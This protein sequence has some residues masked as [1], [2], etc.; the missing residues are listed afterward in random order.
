MPRSNRFG[1]T[2]ASLAVAAGLGAS[3]L[4]AR[5]AEVFEVYSPAFKDGD[6]WPMK[7]T[8]PDPTPNGPPCTG[9]NVSPPVAWKNAPAATK[10]FTLIMYDIDGGNGLGSV[11]WVAYDIPPTK[12]SMAENEASTKVNGWFGG[13]N[14]G[15]HDHYFGPCGP[16]GHAPHHYTITVMAT[17]IAP[18][19]LKPGLTRD[20][21]L[22]AVRGHAL[23]G[24]TIVGRFGRPDG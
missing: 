8:R 10:S 2:V 21:L 5:A 1:M 18:G 24:A 22:A 6:L 12:T 9:Q 13:K 16:P 7:Y 23:D 17:D 19:T 4:P 15:G 20:E 11:H 14:N 3:S